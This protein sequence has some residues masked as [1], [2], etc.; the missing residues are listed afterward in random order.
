LS[1]RLT[2][3]LSFCACAF[4]A[5]Q[6]GAQNTTGSI[7]GRVVT[8]T[9]YTVRAIVTLQPAVALG[10]PSGR[11]HRAFAASNGTFA[12]GAVPPGKY[13]ICTQIPAS[14]APKSSAPFLD[15]CEWG[16][17]SS[18]VQVGA[19]KQANGVNLTAPKGTL[20]QIQVVD[21]DHVLP[22]PTSA[23][24]PAALEP[25]L[26]LILRGPDRR[27]HHAGFVSQNAAGRNY[28]A[29]IPSSTALKITVASSVANVFDQNGNKITGELPTQA[30]AGSATSALTFTL[31]RLGN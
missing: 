2:A 15:T 28:Q 11:L 9:G 12:F 25:Q 3:Y 26:V 27:I 22:A 14:E 18:P 21:P 23:N 1:C 17:S 19:G 20:L 13:T 31:H 8:E 16:S 30:A 5:P 6:G 4:L 7:S 24:G 10:Y 29:V